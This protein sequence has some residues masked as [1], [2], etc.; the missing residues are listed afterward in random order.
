[1]WNFNAKSHFS[2]FITIKMYSTM[3]MHKTSSVAKHYNYIYASIV[4][5]LGRILSWAAIPLYK[6]TKAC[7]YMKFRS[8]H[9]F[10]G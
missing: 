4:A 2:I 6:Y 5:D 8:V 3:C 1:M 9:I 10:T 7:I